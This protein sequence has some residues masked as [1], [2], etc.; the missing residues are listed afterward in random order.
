MGIPTSGLRAQDPLY[1]DALAVLQP[2]FGGTT[3]PEW[4]R[5]T[6]AQGLLSVALYGRNCKDPEQV[7]ALTSELRKENPD[8]LVAIDEEGGDVTRL[9]VVGGSSWPGSLAL[10]AIDDLAVTRDVARELGHSLAACGV[11]FNWAP[12]ADVNANP[13]NPVIGVRAFGADTQL[14]ARH[15][16]AWVEGLQSVGVA[17]CAKHFPGHGDT[18]VDSH[19]GLPSIEVSE[20]VLRERDLVPFQAAIDQD[21]KAVMTAHIMVNALDTEHPATLSRRV[22]T[23]LLRA[24]KS[25]GGLGYNG[26]IVTDGIEMGAIA[27][28]YGVARGTVLALAAGAD[29]ICTGGDSFGEDTVI[30]LAGAIVDAVHAGELPEERLVDAAS[31]VRALAAWTAEQAHPDGRRAPD[32]AVGLAA[33]R[34]ALRVTRGAQ[35]DPVTGPVQVATFSP[36][37][38]CAAGAETPWGAATAIGELLPGSGQETYTGDQAAADGTDVLVAKVLGAAGERRTVAVVRDAHRHPWMAEA[39]TALVAAR[40]DTIV[41]EMGVPQA[42]PTGALH[43]ATF[44]AAPVCGRAAAEVIAGR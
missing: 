5:R 2:G 18:A 33:A 23:S 7:A 13:D 8:I 11:N 20:T 27:R 19:L 40:P 37:A 30:E 3:A 4:V 44:G 24:P 22:L 12:S 31:R 6:V 43:I 35:H 28:T 39:L 10:G 26:L 15:T 41:V 14:C 16:A 1:A 9:E 25:E 42:E 34:Q 36:E 38:N 32:A 21:V 29:A 17:A